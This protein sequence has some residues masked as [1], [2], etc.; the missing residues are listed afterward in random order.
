MKKDHPRYY[1][2]CLKSYKTHL[3]MKLTF[4]LL[5]ASIMVAM[6][7]VRAQRINLNQHKAQLKN[8]LIEISRQS[9]YT[10]IYDEN[11]LKNIKPIT[12][13]ANN[14]SITSLLDELLVEKSLDYQIKG[15]SIAIGRK[16]TIQPIA[17]NV[18]DNIQKRTIT[19]RVTNENGQA[20]PGINVLLK[21]SAIG[22]STN[23]QGEFS[24]SVP[25]SNSLLIISS[26]GYATAEIP[27]QGKNEINVVL[28][29]A[30]SNL[31]EVVV[32]GFGTQKK[33]NLTGAV[34]TVSAKRLAD[35][36][37]A[38]LGQGLQGLVPNL[39]ITSA[40]G[41]PGTG[42]QFT[43]R[44]TG[45]I[46]G[47]TAGPLILVDGVQRDPNSI[48]PSDVE[49]VT[50][51]KDA[52]AAA[53]YGGRAAYG[54][55]LI[56]TKNPKSQN[57]Q[58]NYTGEYTVSRPTKMAKYINSIDYIRMHRQA[59]RNGQDGGTTATESFTEQDSILANAYF[60]D[61]A[62]NLPVYVDPSNPAK[63]RYVGNT[64]WIKEQ[65]PGWA[66]MQ[67]H[68][69]SLQGGRGATSV[70][71]SL[72]Y[73]QQKGLFKEAGQK[74]Q[75]LNPSMKVNSEITDW[76][77]LT[78]NFALTH[79]DDK[80]TAGVVTGGT[81]SGWISGDLRP[82]MPIRHP[83]GNFSGQGSF[84]NPF[85]VAAN[86]GKRK[87]YSNDLWLTGGV[88]IKPIEHV[89]VV[90]DYTWNAYNNFLQSHQ[91]PFKEYGVNG[92]LLGTFPW[93]NPSSV[94]ETT[95]NH[96]YFALNAFAT[97]ENTFAEK[98][99]FKAMV[100]INRESSRYKRLGIFANNLV[101]P[102]KPAINLNNDPRPSVTGAE[103]EWALFGTVFRLNY[104][105][106][107]K[108]L[109][110]ING[111]YDGSSRFSADK[112]YVFTPSVSAGWRI[113]EEN[114][115]E[116]I[117]D[118]VNDLKLRASYGELPNQGFNSDDLYSA[119]NFYPYL[120][121]MPV[122]NSVGYIFG[123]QTG[124]SV[125]AP[126]LVSTNFTWEKSATTNFG[127]DFALLK[128]RLTGSFD[129]YER[130]TRDM[131]V[132]GV[133]L[134]S[135]LGTA[136]PSQNAGT[137]VTK[138]W[139]LSV[140]WNDRIGDDLSYD[141]MLSLSDN[142]AKLTK[143]PLNTT[144]IFNNWYEG[145]LDGEIWGFETQGYFQSQQEI[146]SAPK[147]TQVWGG[148]WRPGDIRYADLNNDGK[149]DFGNNTVG[150]PGDR[151]IIGNSTPRYS[152]GLNMGLNYKN[153]DF[154]AFL[155]GIGKRDT[156]ISNSAFWGFTSE[157]NVP[158]VYATDYWTP[159]NRDAYFPRLRFGNGGNSQQQTKY[160]QNA[161]YLRVK[162]L[163]LGYSLPKRWTEKA[164]L[165]RA[166]VY[167]SGQNLL[168]FTSLFDAFD[169]EVLNFQD[170]PQ[171]KS[172][173]FGLQLGF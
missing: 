38:N 95:D 169:P 17:K 84:T 154:S 102:T 32:V 18:N 127:L 106:D 104:I 155:Q 20:L 58:I 7:N 89:S 123:N 44:G 55:I 133:P 161:A 63:Y 156:W 149:I 10:F 107:K 45:S 1:Y 86:N 90:A 74:Y 144:K 13:S 145:K 87:R 57:P 97:Y 88:K 48:D 116:G 80:E 139:E 30:N 173:A 138:G 43:I 113:S 54:V 166:R 120:P 34:A 119:S 103:N 28:K 99:Y 22:T 9:G 56:Q 167:I 29:A 21:G 36:P 14:K 50:V 171:S 126:G 46:N 26:V 15:R 135:V 68:N 64:D 33:E 129:L 137:L 130:R 118:V 162:Q 157:W 12:I 69:L 164:K 115:M 39:N 16:P 25:E 140:G 31:E 3:S 101:D 153:F 5:L 131:L 65:Y 19:G 160:L 125:G 170:A 158:F 93:T 78:G 96:N 108:Y 146:D 81:S 165:G 114:F 72:G 159:E 76:L 143:Y 23:A 52:A 112:R 111:R 100:G 147:Q 134:P 94:S 105:F 37:I 110:E 141:V 8:I 117:K 73:L 92:I 85:A 67:R 24:L 142:H 42:S 2:Q 132:A 61:P 121:T 4:V 66:P 163:T 168:T 71:T 136:A 172:V 59:N 60:N 41:K 6:G 128:N 47:G 91:I 49:N 150:N 35:R 70:I 75:R 83:D 151:K 109:L 51:L 98:H 62:N 77:T 53:I 79:I 82:T 124:V 11:D 122:N 40:N 27:T 148:T 152:F